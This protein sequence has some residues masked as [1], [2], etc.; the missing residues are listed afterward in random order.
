[1]SVVSGVVDF[2]VDNSATID[3][4]EDELLK[5]EAWLSVSRKPSCV[6]IEVGLGVETEVFPTLAVCV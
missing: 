3:G 4:V 6:A 5:L 1:M 2:V